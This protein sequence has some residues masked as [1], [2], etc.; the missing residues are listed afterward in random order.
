MKDKFKVRIGWRFPEVIQAAIIARVAI[1]V[2]IAVDEPLKELK[3]VFQVTLEILLPCFGYRHSDTD[4]YCS[5]LAWFR[6]AESD[7]PERNLDFDRYSSSRPA[8]MLWI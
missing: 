6:K 7:S 3:R 8:G 4:S 2:R 1:D 5:D